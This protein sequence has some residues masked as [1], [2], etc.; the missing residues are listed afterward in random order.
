M[1]LSQKI[2]PAFVYGVSRTRVRCLTLG[3]LPGC[4]RCRSGFREPP[5]T[6]PLVSPPR[7][8]AQLKP[9]VGLVSRVGRGGGT[10]V[11]LRLAYP[12]PPLGCGRQPLAVIPMAQSSHLFLC[13]RGLGLDLRVFGGRGARSRTSL[14][15]HRSGALPRAFLPSV[16][17]APTHTPCGARFPPCGR[18]VQTARIVQLEG[19][20]AFNWSPIDCKLAFEKR[21]T[22]WVGGG[23]YLSSEDRPWQT[24]RKP[25][26]ARRM[27]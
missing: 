14:D 22:L 6:R 16:R 1:R 19:A 24:G 10:Q 7:G 26:P 3:P 25:A 23:F 17:A 9:A 4:R 27:G 15:D 21:T 18:C 12:C 11:A 2:R 13:L 8:K 5:A 20:C